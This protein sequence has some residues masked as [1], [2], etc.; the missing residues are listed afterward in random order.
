MAITPAKEVLSVVTF[1]MLLMEIINVFFFF[2]MVFQVNTLAVLSY[3]LNKIYSN[4]FQTAAR[5]A[6]YVGCTGR[7]SLFPSIYL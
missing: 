5:Y 6:S 1:H 2:F 4:I 7:A 3:C